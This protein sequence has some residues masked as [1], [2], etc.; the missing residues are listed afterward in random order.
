MAAIIA[1]VGSVIGYVGAEVAEESLFE[2]ILWPQ[3]FYNVLDFT[4]AVKLTILTPMGGPLHRAA[5][6][7]LDHF[8]QHGLYSGRAV[9]T[10]LGTAF[11]PDRGVAYSHHNTA[12]EKER[13]IQKQS[14]NCIW[15]EVLRHIKPGTQ[16]STTVSRNAATPG[17]EAQVMRKVKRSVHPVF[18]LRLEVIAVDALPQM[19][20]VIKENHFTIWM[21]LG[22]LL[23]ELVSVGVAV[24]VGAIGRYYVFTALLGIPI[25]FKLLAIA[26]SVQREDFQLDHL[27]PKTF[28]PTPAIGQLPPE[29]TPP[30]E[31]Q[32]QFFELLDPKTGISLIETSH[33]DIL[34][35]FTRHYGHPLRATSLDR[36]MEIFN[37]V[38]VYVFA[39]KFPAELIALAWAPEVVQWMWLAYQVYAVSAMHLARLVGW[40]GCGRTEGLLAKVL[41][42][43]GIAYLASGNGASVVRAVLDVEVFAGVAEA[44]ARRQ[45]ILSESLRLK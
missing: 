34:H 22:V 6:G 35:T 26:V 5:I 20:T 31:S 23:S 25:V 13:N 19:A 24:A 21:M 12:T 4:T 33:P 45:E 39:L 37:I 29:P 36:T 8:R 44:E 9:G 42:D 27:L 17:I 11:F 41:Q 14:R 2:R 28:D 16:A 10:M 1:A 38:I 32:L 18:R 7:V 40:T 3:R 30:A 43:N 15:V